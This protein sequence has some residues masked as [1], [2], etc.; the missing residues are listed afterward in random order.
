[1]NE[2]KNTILAIVLSLIVVVGWE[3]FFARPQL[4]QQAQQQ[5]HHQALPG[6][7]PPAT[8]AGPAPQAPSAPSAQ[9]PAKTAAQV[10]AASPRVEID[11]PTLRGSID[12]KG[13]RI[14]NLSLTQYRETIAPDSSPIGLLS[15]SG[16]PDA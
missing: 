16:A 14:D 2:Y 10:I 1:M 11:T 9:P 5:E 12:L 13:A 3:Y 6:T 15:P 7:A 4:Q 8:P